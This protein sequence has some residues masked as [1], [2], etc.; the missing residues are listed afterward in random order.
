MNIPTGLSIAVLFMLS[1]VSTSLAIAQS[2]AKTPPPGPKPTAASAKCHSLLVEFQG[3]DENY[4]AQ[5]TDEELVN[6]QSSIDDCLRNSYLQLSRLDLAVA[7]VA[8]AIVARQ[9]Q[10]RLDEVAY[11]ALLKNYTDLQAKTAPKLSSRTVTL[12]ISPL[13]RVNAH[14]QCDGTRER[15]RGSRINETHVHDK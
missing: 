15:L 10:A 14:A 8:V 6:I 7:G 2:S 12:T 4:F 1:L 3:K 13:T 11:G 5:K 9:L